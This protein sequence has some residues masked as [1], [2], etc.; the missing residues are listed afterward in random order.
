[1]ENLIFCEKQSF[2]FSVT[3]LTLN[4]ETPPPSLPLV[5]QQNKSSSPGSY[6]LP[7]R[8]SQSTNWHKLKVK[9]IN[10]YNFNII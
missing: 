9:T 3:Y 4:E 7:G 10:I 2:Y 8:K 6:T 5:Y 1:M